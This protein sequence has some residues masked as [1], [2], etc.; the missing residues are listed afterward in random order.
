MAK[1]HYNEENDKLIHVGDLVAKGDKNV[2]V[3]EWM[4]KH[5]IQGVRGNHD[6]P[7]IQWRAWMEWAGGKDWESFVNS[8]ASR[9]D[10]AVAKLLTKSGKRFPKDYEWKGQHWHIAREMKERHYRYLLDLPLA[11]HMP[12]LH[13]FVIHAGMLPHNPRKSAS[14]KSQP[15]VKASNAHSSS[16]NAARF[17]EEL[18]LLD[19]VK[20]NTDPY[21]LLNMRSVF[22]KG[23]DKGD[24]T[25]STK[26]GEPWSDVWTEQMDRCTVAQFE[27]RKK[28]ESTPLECA[29][30]T[31][32]YGH[33]A[34]RGLDVKKY[35]K[36]IDTGCVYG[37]QLTALVIGDL[38]LTKGEKAYVGEHD[39]VLVNIECG[40][41]GY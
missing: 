4:L 12:S 33:A 37:R 27:K 14:H 17:A 10:D 30:V 35:S 40:E 21:T 29:P 9:D 15:L 31:L 2:E 18:S 34:G 38:S 1:L 24:I 5:N 13:S 11:L 41:G 28:H 39:G 25:K 20:Q 16:V 26:E 8:L 19:D 22:M 23:K 36:G 7:V 6:Q 32:V 3:L